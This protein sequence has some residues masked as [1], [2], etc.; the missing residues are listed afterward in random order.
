MLFPIVFGAI[1]VT[2]AV[3]QAPMLGKPLR[4]TLKKISLKKAQY[5]PGRELAAKVIPPTAWKAK[6]GRESVFFV[7]L[8]GDGALT[9]KNDGIGMT[10]A[11]FVV[12]IPG[13]LLLEAGQFRVSFEGTK[14]LILTPEVFGR[15]DAMVRDAG[16]LTKLRIRA[17]LTPGTIDFAAC[18]ACEKH[19][20]Y[21]RSN[22]LADGRGGMKSHEET[23]GRPGY[24]EAGRAAAKASN[25]YWRQASLRANIL[26]CYATIWHGVPI[27]DPAIVKF[28]VYIQNGNTMFLPVKRR[29][30]KERVLHPADGAIG[31]PTT[32]GYEY[33]SPVPGSRDGGGCGF[34]VMILLPPRAAALVKAVLWTKKRQRPIPGTQSC[35]KN[36]ANSSWP[37]NSMTAAFIPSRPLSARTTY[38]A[39]F[40]FA[41]GEPVQWTFTTGR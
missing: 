29:Q 13:T 2:T 14:R 6:V 38:V 19:H 5:V 3:G 34:P 40:E 35:P 23:A 27:V 30:F 20:A 8:D 41:Q 26:T 24:S 16:V 32:F 1:L 7:D 18:E 21:M 17:G 4:I 31:I 12:S 15:F 28:G 9:V 37:T 36:P 33:P 39:R 22:G 11:R 10:S 25:I